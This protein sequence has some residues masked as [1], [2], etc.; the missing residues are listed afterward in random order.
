MRPGAPSRAASIHQ[1]GRRLIPAISTN[2][3]AKGSGDYHLISRT[4]GL[5]SAVQSAS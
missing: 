5:S 2:R 4:L 1:A 3:R